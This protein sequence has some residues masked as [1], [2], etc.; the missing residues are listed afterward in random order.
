MGPENSYSWETEL[1]CDGKDGNEDCGNEI[2]VKYEVYEYPVG[3]FNM[4]EVVVTGGKELSR[5]GYDFHDAP[6][7]DFDEY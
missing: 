3:A 7:Q 2:S 1:E 6:D 5:F 4:D